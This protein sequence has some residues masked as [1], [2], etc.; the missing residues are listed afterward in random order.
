MHVRRYGR[1][2]GLLRGLIWLASVALW[3]WIGH[4]ALCPWHLRNQPLHWLI[5]Y[6]VWLFI[7]ALGDLEAIP[8][9]AWEA[10]KSN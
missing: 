6:G 4:A 10:L 1:A 2:A 8:V 9:P 3:A 7:V 5:G